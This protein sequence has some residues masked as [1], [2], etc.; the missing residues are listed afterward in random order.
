MTDRS[1]IISVFRIPLGSVLDRSGRSSSRAWHAPRGVLVCP[2]RCS[3]Q[4]T[5]AH[6]DASQ[7]PGLPELRLW[8]LRTR[9]L[10]NDSPPAGP[11]VQ[12]TPPRG[13]WA[14][15]PAARASWA[16]AATAKPLRHP[17]RASPQS[18]GC[19][20]DRTKPP[21]SHGPSSKRKACATPHRREANRK[22]NWE[23]LNK[24][25]VCPGDLTDLLLSSV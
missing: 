15:Y 4:A 3:G 22:G 5:P 17:R 11:K 2:R 21:R 18:A 10:D 14:A 16:A 8:P 7:A 13:S 9:R 20:P 19:R 23:G 12:Q 24:P 1:W 6:S 25:L